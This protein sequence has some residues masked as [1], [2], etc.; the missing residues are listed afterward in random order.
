LA[1]QLFSPQVLGLLAALVVVVGV[2]IY[3]LIPA[4][5]DTLYDG[6]Q[7]A[8]QSGSIDDLRQVESKLDEFIE[9]YPADP[10]VEEIRS[11]KEKILAE[12]RARNARIGGRSPSSI[13][14]QSP[15]ERAYVEATALAATQPERAIAKLQALV[16]LYEDADLTEDDGRSFIEIAKKDVLELRLALTQSIE[17]QRRLLAAQVER[18]QA[19]SAENPARAQEMWQSIITLYADKPWA[20]KIVKQA[21]DA[22][23]KLKDE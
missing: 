7:P 9:R 1:E 2:L 22:L 10:R 14:K 16:R 15:I 4:S 21:P 8:A 18:A 6:V 3:L 23:D 20:A 13:E 17:Q 11:L 5:A 19:I 12:R